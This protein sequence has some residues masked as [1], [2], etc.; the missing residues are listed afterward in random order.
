MTV[1]QV[2]IFDAKNFCCHISQLTHWQLISGNIPHPEHFDHI[3]QGE[4][5]LPHIISNLRE[6]SMQQIVSVI[7]DPHDILQN[8][9]EQDICFDSKDLIRRERNAVDL[10]DQRDSKGQCSSSASKKG[11]LKTIKL[12][13]NILNKLQAKF[14]AYQLLNAM[15]SGTLGTEPFD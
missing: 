4:E 14:P 5:S 3:E 11:F 15:R 10:Y 2:T 12:A 1:R 8:L 9:S 6:E 13:M 7:H